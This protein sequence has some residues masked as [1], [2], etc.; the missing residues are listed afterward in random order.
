MS[1]VNELPP[2]FMFTSAAGDHR[3]NTSNLPAIH[4]LSIN[5]RHFTNNFLP[6]TDIHEP[7]NDIMAL[8]QAPLEEPGYSFSQ[9][10]SHSEP[11]QHAFYPYAFP[12][13]LPPSPN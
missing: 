1:F 5:N 13:S 11:R 7:D 4:L 6:A 8:Y 9:P 2:G 3:N 12:S 10:T